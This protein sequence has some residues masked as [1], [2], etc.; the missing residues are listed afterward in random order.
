MVNGT[1]T[2]AS[3]DSLD[4]LAAALAKA[5]AEIKPVARTSQNPF[6]GSSYAD[7]SAV[8]ECCRLALT[9]NGFC[10]IQGVQV[11][12]DGAREVFDKKGQVEIE[13]GA[14]V[15]IETK[16]LHS[17]GQWVSMAITV[18]SPDEGPQ[19]VGRCITYGRRYGIST[20]I[21]IASEEDTDGND[22]KGPRESKGASG[23]KE[24]C[25][26][27]GQPA[28]MKSKFGEGFYCL[29]AAGGCGVKIAKLEKKSDGTG[30]AKSEA[31]TSE[32][33]KRK[34]WEICGRLGIQGDD[35][36]I[37]IINLPA[38]VDGSKVA[39]GK[40]LVQGDGKQ[41]LYPGRMTDAEMQTLIGELEDIEGVLAG[42]G[43]SK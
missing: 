32:A 25:P 38:T 18:R 40:V 24:I 39:P 16:L 27:C 29:P 15:T 14:L 10:V 34:M 8:W 1:K 4:L 9:S 19:D 33:I 31:K 37:A 26:K 20:L 7:L 11:A 13:H 5:Q 41:L 17:S 23:N 2:L 30:A 6:F 36:G 3:S 43:D 35:E 22:P 21:G 42:G 12:P 28:L